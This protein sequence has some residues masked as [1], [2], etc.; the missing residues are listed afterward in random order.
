MNKLMGNIKLSSGINLFTKKTRINLEIIYKL[1]YT[2]KIMIGL[3][4]T[5]P[6]LTLVLIGVYLVMT[7]VLGFGSWATI[8]VLAIL[9]AV[10]AV[11]MFILNK[12]KWVIIIGIIIILI[13]AGIIVL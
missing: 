7:T 2:N 13:S 10:Y 9:T 6:I 4:I 11:V 12:M 3:I 8:G 1:Q 5:L